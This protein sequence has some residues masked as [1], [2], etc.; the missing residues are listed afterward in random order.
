MS[1]SI[2]SALKTDVLAEPADWCATKWVLE[3]TPYIFSGVESSVLWRWKQDLASR[4]D[5]D[6]KNI[7]VTGSAAVGISTNPSKG[8]KP[9]DAGSDIDVAVVSTYHFDVAW[10][11]LRSL[12]ARELSLTSEQKYAIQMHMRRLIYWGTIATDRVLPLLPFGQ[13]WLHALTHI[14]TVEPTLNRDVKAR[15]YRDYASVRAYL[16][17]TFRSL[18]DSVA[19]GADELSE[20]ITEEK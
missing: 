3:A 6:P 4:L 11:A 12:G 20:R 7:L 17:H 15:I 9:F 2:R 18:R 10:R 13:S 5:V 19:G 16:H 14:A 1:E 8:L